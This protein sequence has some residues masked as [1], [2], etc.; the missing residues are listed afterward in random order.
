MKQH[1]VLYFILSTD[2]CV[3]SVKMA[4]T[5]K[6][7]LAGGSTICETFALKWSK[8]CEQKDRTVL[9]TAVDSDV[10]V[11]S[12]GRV[13]DSLNLTEVWTLAIDCESEEADRFNLSEYWKGQH[14]Q[15]KGLSGNLRPYSSWVGRRQA[16]K[17]ESLQ[18][19]AKEAIPNNLKQ[20]L[21]TTWQQ[22][23]TQQRSTAIQLSKI[24]LTQQ[25]PPQQHRET[26]GICSR[27]S[28]NTGIS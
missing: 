6:Q 13:V 25:S 23:R 15:H 17:D 3:S 4:T 1:L 2:M 18:R 10:W 5:R 12:K 20:P 26:S 8:A 28:S 7:V 21:A 11:S 16:D 22:N 14:P 27:R 9:Q 24:E 19:L